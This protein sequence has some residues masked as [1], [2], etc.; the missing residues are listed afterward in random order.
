GDRARAARRVLRRPPGGLPG[1][2]GSPAA[3]ARQGGVPHLHAARRLLHPDRVRALP[4][5]LRPARRHGLRP[6]PREG[7]RRGDGARLLLLPPPGAGADE[8]PV[9]LPEDRRRPPGR[10]APPP[11]AR[12]LTARPVADAAPLR[13]AARAI[14][15]AAIAAGDA[16][17]LTR[18]A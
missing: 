18:R 1:A 15:D 4:R 13:K 9:R 16:Y 10:G 3:P 5:A 12:R 7:G 11:S 8:D 14:L 2:P 17:E 6:V